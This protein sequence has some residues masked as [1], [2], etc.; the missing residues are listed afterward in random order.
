MTCGY[1]YLN[2]LKYNLYLFSCCLLKL[3]LLPL[4]NSNAYLVGVLFVRIKCHNVGEAV[5]IA[6]SN[7]KYLQ[8]VEKS[9]GV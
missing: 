2:E 5:N 1:Q 6:S 9:V 4:V 3:L 7:L 8:Q